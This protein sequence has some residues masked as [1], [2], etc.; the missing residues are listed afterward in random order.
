MKDDILTHNWGRLFAVQF[1]A[2]KGV[3]TLKPIYSGAILLPNYKSRIVLEA[4]IVSC[5]TTLAF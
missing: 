3:K 1:T 2:V 4:S 5:R